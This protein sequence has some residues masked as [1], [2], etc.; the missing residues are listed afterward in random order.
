MLS[1]SATLLLS[2]ICLMATTLTSQTLAPIDLFCG[3]G[4]NLWVTRYEPLD[5]PATIEA[6]I[7]YTTRHYHL[8][9]L[10]WRSIG[11]WV[12]MRVG[13][14]KS[15]DSWDWVEWLRSLD[16][17][18]N[19]D[20][21]ASRLAHK[22]G[23][24]AYIYCGLFE[25]GLSPDAF[26]GYRFEFIERLNHP[27]W[28]G[29][30]RWGERKEPGA[31]S[32]AI[33][34]ARAFLVKYFTNMLDKNEFDGICF[35]TYV[36]NHA[37]H[38]N[39]EFGFEPA[40]VEMFNAKYPDIDLK[41][42]STRLTEEQAEYWYACRGHF[43]T[44]FLQELADSL[45]ARGK[46]LGMSLPVNGLEK[47]GYAQ[48]WWNVPICGNGR[49][50]LEYEKWID[51]GIVD[52]IMAQY[53]GVKPQQAMLDHIM[54]LVKGKP[55][56]LTVRSH[57][58]YDPSWRRYREAGVAPH[59]MSTK[60][61]HGAER[62]FPGEITLKSLKADDWCERAQAC[63]DIASGKL[64]GVSDETVKTLLALADDPAVLVRRARCAALA[65]LAAQGRPELVP[66][67][68]AAL[69]DLTEPSVRIA[70]AL[71]LAKANR[72]E[73]LA[74]LFA[75][76]MRHPKEFQLKSTIV[77]TVHAMGAPTYGELAR[78]LAS[79]NW[80]ECEVA[81]RCLYRLVTKDV[82][83]QQEADATMR[84]F[85]ALLEDNTLD[86]F[87]QIVL[88]SKAVGMRLKVSAPVQRELVATICRLLEGSPC[89]ESQL[90]AGEMAG[91]LDGI[92]TETERPLLRQRLA[93][94]FRD[95]GDASRRP[96]AAYGWRDVGNSM[97]QLGF[98]ADLEALMNQ[99]EDAFTAYNAYKVL[100]DPQGYNAESRK[101][102][103]FN[104]ID[105]ATAIENHDKFAPPFPGSRRW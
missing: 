91:T 7:D 47:I 61:G 16:N 55:V 102:S 92:L 80:T 11:N 88:V 66:A 17:Q 19:A 72:P 38:Y 49:I 82:V 46:K 59:V 77:D 8:R 15:E 103:G 81:A 50:R 101:T 4:D 6:M 33:P 83:G 87:V 64:T 36:E 9:R 34:E 63:R 20:L 51:E 29:T 1:K 39:H 44:L 79:K 41:R 21:T 31:I 95:Y 56:E 37:I 10:Y 2:A 73:S 93:V 74:R 45:H 78:R 26:A 12:G 104:L 90:K 70:A 85:L 57:N 32:F 69:D 60:P 14:T 43:V 5:S 22:H 75:A 54:P 96:A 30:D 3:T 100:Y 67:I 71:A 94:L 48:T 86:A 25:F 52:E 53:D 99:R 65:T 23:M 58:P 68:E 89:W 84:S 27:E 62:Y 40:V 76:I 42:E 97:V 105:E 24:Q 28:V 98:R 13:R 18:F 35:Y